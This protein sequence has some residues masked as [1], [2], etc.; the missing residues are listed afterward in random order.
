M[1]ICVVYMT[2]SGSGPAL[3]V[4]ISSEVLSVTWWGCAVRDGFGEWSISLGVSPG[5]CREWRVP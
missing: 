5:G 3:A 4:Y 1:N 2:V